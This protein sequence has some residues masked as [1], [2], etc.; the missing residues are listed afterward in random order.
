LGKQLG[1]P[2]KWKQLSGRTIATFIK[3]ARNLPNRC[4][5]GRMVAT[6][7]FLIPNYLLKIWSIFKNKILFF[8]F[9]QFTSAH[10]SYV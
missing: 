6:L 1:K 3:N 2:Q 4:H 8:V 5:H 9:I 7:V 10:T